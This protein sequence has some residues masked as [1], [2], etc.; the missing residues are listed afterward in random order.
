[1]TKRA[2]VFLVL[3]SVS[4][5]VSCYFHG[6]G[7]FIFSLS[8]HLDEQKERSEQRRA[9]AVVTLGIRMHSYIANFSTGKKTGRFVSLSLQSSRWRHRYC[10]WIA[11]DW[12]ILVK[13]RKGTTLFHRKSFQRER[14]LSFQ[15]LPLILG[16]FPTNLPKSVCFMVNEFLGKWI[17]PTDPFCPFLLVLSWCANTIPP[18]LFVNWT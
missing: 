1:M 3:Y 11:W 4:V 14:R 8:G 10:P 18:F 15:S 7:G 6:G 12:E 5:R 2:T 16:S 9:K 17:S 13:I